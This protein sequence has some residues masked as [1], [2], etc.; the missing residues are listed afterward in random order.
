MLNGGA[1]NV[2]VF[3]N[4][5]DGG[6]APAPSS[7]FAVGP[8]PSAIAVG[9]FKTKTSVDIAVT[10]Q[11]VVGATGNEVSILLNNGNGSF[12]VAK[13]YQVGN[14]PMALAMADY[15]G[16][17][18]GDLAVA[19]QADGTVSVISN[20]GNGTFTAPVTLGLDGGSPQPNAIVAT[21]LNGDGKYDLAV[22]SNVTNDVRVFLNG[23]GS[24]SG[25]QGPFA[26]GTNPT[27]LVAGNFNGNAVSGLNDLAVT[28]KTTGTVSVLINKTSTTSPQTALF[29]PQATYPLNGGLVSI[30]TG[31]FNADALPDLAIVNST[32]KTVSILLGQC[33]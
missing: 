10:D 33:P 23:S 21:D 24:W 4:Q 28:N 31:L 22:A 15:D 12:A 2:A 32:Q 5:G 20:N 25:A 7:P 30:A 29:W 26:V 3:L 6:F 18:F 17:G 8:S 27:S 16:D 19:N 11:G 14:T 13:A 9:N 1:A